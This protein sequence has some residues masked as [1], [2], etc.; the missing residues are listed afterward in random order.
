MNKSQKSKTPKSNNLNLLSTQFTSVANKKLIS[1]NK[2]LTNPTIV[3]KS[4]NGNPKTPYFVALNPVNNKRI[5]ARSSAELQK[6][7]KTTANINNS[8][9]NVKKI[10]DFNILYFPDPA[11]YK[12][13]FNGY[14]SNDAKYTQ[15]IAK[16][17]IIKKVKEKE[18]ADKKHKTYMYEINFD[19]DITQL[20][21]DINTLISGT[22]T[23][24]INK[25][26]PTDKIRIILSNGDDNT[27]MS[28]PYMYIKDFLDT[29]MTAG[30]IDLDFDNMIVE[31]NNGFEVGDNTSI[32]ISVQ[33]NPF[34][35]GRGK[36]ISDKSKMYNKSSIIQIKNDDDLCLGRCIVCELADV[37]NH[38]QKKQIRMGRKIQTELTHQLYE[39]NGIEKCLPTLDTI[40]DFEKKLNVSITIVDGDAFNNIIYPDVKSPD[41][42]PKDINIYLYKTQN[43]YDLINSKKIKGF[44]AKTNFCHKCKKGYSGNNH[45]CNWKCNICC[46]T[47]CD[48]KCFDFK[49]QSCSFDCK[50]CFRWFPT[51]KCIDNHL[52]PNKTTGKSVCDKI[53]KCPDCKKIMDKEK[54]IPA[55]HK[56]GDFECHNCK[57]IVDK[58][59]KCYMMPKHIHQPSD[60]YIYFDF[61]CDIVS[62]EKHIPNYCVAQ[63]H[64]LDENFTF[65]SCDEFCKWIFQEKHNKYT[66]IAHN[67]RGYDFQLIMEWIYKHTTYKPFTIYAGSKIMTFSVKGEYEIRFLDS[68]NF[69]TMPLSAFPK[70]FGL[71]ELKKG[72]YPYWFNTKENWNYVGPLPDKKYYKPNQMK[73]E[74][75]AEF[76]EWYDNLKKNNFV[77]NHELETKNY[78][79]SDVDI[80]R[81][82]CEEF[83]KL[84][85]Q[86]ADIDPFCYTTIASVCMAIYKANYIVKDYNKMYWEMKESLVGLDAPDRKII[87]DDFDNMIRN[88]VFSEKKIA[89]FNYKDTE[90]MRKSF[91]GGRTNATKLKYTFTGTEEGKY[92]DITSLYPSVNYYDEYPLGHPIEI[93]KNFKQK[94]D[95]EYDIDD[96]TGFIDCDVICPKDLYF[97]VLANKGKKLFFDLID[98]R[99]VWA[100]NEVK[101]AVQMGYKIKKIY[102]IFHFEN[103]S[104]DLFKGYIAKFLKVKQEA[105]GLPKWITEPD[106]ENCVS[107]KNYPEINLEYI[108]KLSQDQ[109]IDLYIKL[110]YENQGIMMNKHNIKKNP[111]LRAIAKLCLNS[112]WGKFGQR[113]NMPKTEIITDNKK[114]WDIMFNDKYTNQ[115]YWEI[116]ENRIEMSYKLQDEYVKNDFNTNIAI[117]SFTTSSAR[118]RLYAGLEKLNRQVL[119]HDTDSIVYVYDPNNPNHNKMEI[120]DYL[121]EWTDELEGAKMIGTFISGGPKNYSYETDDGEY[122]TKIKGFTLNYDAVKQLNHTNMINMITKHAGEIGPVRKED[123]K[124]SA[125]YDMINRNKDKSLSNYHQTKNY[126]FGYDKRQIQSPDN[127]GNIDTYPWGYSK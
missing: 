100:S 94:P 63:Y 49:T 102:K 2:Y 32:S 8:I 90:F 118:L 55:L 69:L 81:R 126:G 10:N 53:W 64:G 72:F 35:A 115:N 52:I 68:L 86:I 15:E 84:Y 5:I 24:V 122:H 71:K 19:E 110:Y 61:E 96:I 116:D 34:T 66:F 27:G 113:V 43:H 123:V 107:D 67:G 4:K 58:D 97:P 41:Y 88:Q 91:F 45:K 65:N 95:G 101:K 105:T 125:E 87:Q 20:N 104:N 22:I 60:K 124:L 17:D 74:T 121:G 59:H 73:T 111:G 33:T 54:F 28:L 13:F 29:Y 120:G 80:L 3:S 25:H 31:S 78:C 30:F 36:I 11:K 9:K 75:R 42:E 109:R 40:M 6:K 117:A 89:V 16:T 70:T 82:S 93:T 44:F 119:Y 98:K 77:Y 12:T 1:D 47:D 26:K 76:N 92:A 57:K 83:R 112:L 50:S 48:S 21:E 7:L 56:C 108:K 38:P 99:G 79:I 23:D 127:L 106:L 14:N 85:I 18:N 39:E 37:N 103:T 46:S 114:Y 51:Q 62:E